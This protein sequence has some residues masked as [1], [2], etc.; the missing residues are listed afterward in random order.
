MTGLAA[1]LWTLGDFVA[2]STTNIDVKHVAEIIRFIG[3]I[4]IPVC[5]LQTCLVYCGKELSTRKLI[6][7][8]I[9]PTISFI[10]VVTNSSHQ[11][12]FDDV[13]WAGDANPLKLT[14]GAAFWYLHAPF[15]YSV[16]FGSVIFL[17]YEFT[18][19]TR[20]YRTQILILIFS[21]SIPILISLASLLGFLEGLDLYP[22]G[23]LGF[24]LMSLFGLTQL[25]RHRKP[26]A[27]ETVFDS[28]SDGIIILD[29]RSHI[30]DIN[31]AALRAFNKKKHSLLNRNVNDVFTSWA[32][33]ATEYSNQEIVNLTEIELVLGARRQFFVI[34]KDPVIGKDGEEIGLILSIRNNTTQRL[35]QRTLESLAFHDPLTRLGNRRKFEEEFEKA[36]KNVTPE[37]PSF[38]I[39][40]I[41]LNHFK[42]VND[43]HGHKIGD[44]LLKFVATRIAAILRKPDMVARLGGDEFAIILYNISTQGLENVVD[45]IIQN[46]KRPFRVMDYE[47]VADLSIGA[48][49]YPRNG[50]TISKLLSH[51][52]SAMY[53]A[54]STGGGLRFFDPAQE[55]VRLMRN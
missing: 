40:Y 16:I 18:R 36:V 2:V 9:V 42:E 53:H 37:N 34:A 43:K 8:S 48:A 44:E 5:I 12:F 31:P 4:T 14:Y 49:F 46:T 22:I 13:E 7:F 29:T 30:M 32:P 6:L 21:V 17:I 39:L 35:N 11:L 50:D 26:I 19:S 54:K 52:D 55:N 41:D 25:K 20:G 45:R 24:L 38:A 51:A 33:Y 47:L 27:Y 23:F 15:S 3:V 10:F 28:A 1:S